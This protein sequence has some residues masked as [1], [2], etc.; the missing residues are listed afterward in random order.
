MENSVKIILVRHGHSIGNLNRTFLGHTDLDLSELGYKQSEA[1]AQCLKNVKIDYIYSSDLKRAV[2]TA[3]PH[4]RMRNLKVI[5]SKKLREVYAGDWEN[6]LV[7]DIISKWGREEFYN[8]WVNNFGCYRF[9]S[10]ESIIEAGKRL[11]NE[12]VNI[13]SGKEG[14]TVLIC[15]HAA[16]IRSFWAIISNVSFEE[17]TNKIPF[18]T[19]ASYSICYYENGIITPFEYSNDA[20]LLDVGITKV[21][22]I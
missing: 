18:A 15:T 21:N 12:I 13:C 14:H 2:N 4:A 7:D 8:K 10:G 16:I 17:I 11:Y 19:N 1:T 22:L 5:M 6:M 9:P 3:I 20:H